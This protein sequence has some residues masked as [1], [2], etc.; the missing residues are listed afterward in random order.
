MINLESIAVDITTEQ[1]SKAQKVID[2][3]T[4]EDFYQVESS[5]GTTD[6]EVRYDSEKGLTCN[7]EAGKHAFAG[8]RNYCWHTRAAAACFLEELEIERKAKAIE[9]NVPAWI[10]R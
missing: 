6:Y 5:D 9:N 1:M 4:N 2:F 3:Q 7:C 10:M 8:C